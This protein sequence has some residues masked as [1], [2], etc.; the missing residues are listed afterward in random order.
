MVVA[1]L[2]MQAIA[3][4]T[5]LVVGRDQT[6]VLVGKN[7]RPLDPFGPGEDVIARESAPRAAAESRPP[8]R[9]SPRA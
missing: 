4:G 2:P 5:R 3:N 8:A 9:S 7:G 1:R 6:A